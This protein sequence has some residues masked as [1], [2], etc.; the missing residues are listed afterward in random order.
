VTVSQCYFEA[1]GADK[2]KIIKSRPD[3]SFH[4]AC[5]VCFYFEHMFDS[6]YVTIY[7]AYW[8]LNL[9]MLCDRHTT[10]RS[11]VFCVD[12]FSIWEYQWKRR[13]LPF[14]KS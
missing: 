7:Q 11:T 6:K 12:V 1:D 13:L 5:S 14:L 8:Y 2:W 4:R 3:C 10:F 9:S